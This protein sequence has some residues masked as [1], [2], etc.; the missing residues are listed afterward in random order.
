MVG[1][2]HLGTLEACSSAQI[3]FISQQLLKLNTPT[4]ETASAMFG[5]DVLYFPMIY[6]IWGLIYGVLFGAIFAKLYHRLPGKTSKQKGIVLGIPVFLI[7]LFAGPAS[8][9]VINCSPTFIPYISQALS[10]PASFA[11]CYI[12]GMFYD[13]FG[14]LEIEQREERE[15]EKLGLSGRSNLRFIIPTIRIALSHMIVLKL[16]RGLRA[17]DLK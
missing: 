5:T 17:A 8:Y 9:Y 15:K 1:L 3:S 11:F 6:G 14:R 12:L 4:N 10:I 7:G 2:L 13:S 16:P